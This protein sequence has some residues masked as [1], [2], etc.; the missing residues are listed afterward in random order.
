MQPIFS[1][2]VKAEKVAVSKKYGMIYFVCKL[3]YSCANS[4]PFSFVCKESGSN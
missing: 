3:N 4:F 1:K 2:L